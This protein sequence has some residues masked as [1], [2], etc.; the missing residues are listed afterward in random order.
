MF[1]IARATHPLVKRSVEAL[2]TI[3]RELERYKDR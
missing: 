3:G 2:E 1:R